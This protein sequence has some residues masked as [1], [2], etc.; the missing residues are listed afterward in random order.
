MAMFARQY[1]PMLAMACLEADEDMLITSR[2]AFRLNFR[3]RLGNAFKNAQNLVII[4][5]RS[6]VQQKLQ[7][8]PQRTIPF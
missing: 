3:L 1:D 7:G 2:S 6:P 5:I 4:K 8:G